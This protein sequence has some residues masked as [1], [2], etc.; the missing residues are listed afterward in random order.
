MNWAL[1]GSRALANSAGRKARMVSDAATKGCFIQSGN[2]SAAY[3]RWATLEKYSRY[4][5]SKRKVASLVQLSPSG[6]VIAIRMNDHT[7]SR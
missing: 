6:T 4:L 3:G 5:L 7:S 1:E 2:T